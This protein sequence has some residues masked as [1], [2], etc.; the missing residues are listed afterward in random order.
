MQIICVLSVCHP[1]GCSYAYIR[2]HICNEYAAEF[3]LLCVG[4]K[5]FSLCSREKR[6]V[7][8]PEFYTLSNKNFK[9]EHCRDFSK[10]QLPLTL[11]DPGCLRPSEIWY[12]HY[13]LPPNIKFSNIKLSPNHL[14]HGSHW[15]MSYILYVH[16]NSIMFVELM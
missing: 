9:A 12:M 7:T 15:C 10:Q 8:T 3:Q 11:C 2:L 6:K 5:S 4:S 16:I 1:E 13:A 14:A